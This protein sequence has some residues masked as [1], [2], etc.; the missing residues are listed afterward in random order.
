MIC[1]AGFIHDVGD[2]FDKHPGGPGYLKNNIGKDA[3]SAF[4]GGLYEHSNAAHNV[5]FY[6]D[7]AE[8]FFLTVTVQLLAMKRVAILL[9]GAA[10]G[11]EERAVPPS[12]HLRVTR[13]N[14]VSK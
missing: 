9:G 10:H 8:L 2:F 5:R 11:L 14:E 7:L 12:Q 6:L 1:I 13:F 3:T 4:F